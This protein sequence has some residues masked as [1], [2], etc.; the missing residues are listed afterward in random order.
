MRFRSHAMPV[1]L[2]LSAAIACSESDEAQTEATVR[3]AGAQVQDAAEG[4]AD[5]VV[6]A[7][8]TAG[9]ALQD[10]AKEVRGEVGADDPDTTVAPQDTLRR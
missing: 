1:V 7:A 2:V 9:A 5:V 6:D 4:A 3:D 10:A 8:G